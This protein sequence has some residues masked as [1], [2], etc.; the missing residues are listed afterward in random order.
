MVRISRRWKIAA[1][2]VAVLVS[3]LV[4]WPMTASVRG[5][6]AGRRDIAKGQYVLLGYGEPGPSRS[7]YVRLLHERYGVEFKAVA[8]CIV[9]ESLVAYV[10]AYDNEVFAAANK[11]F[12][13]DIFK[14]TAEEADRAWKMKLAQY[15]QKHSK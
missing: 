10:D 12:G 14:E 5:R 2:V 6:F 11:K 8:G 1:A 13:H 4:F 9:T 15:Q 3:A 7:D